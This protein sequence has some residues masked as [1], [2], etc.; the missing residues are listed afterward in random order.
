MTKYRQDHLLWETFHNGEDVLGPKNSFTQNR[1]TRWTKSSCFVYEARFGDLYFAFCTQS[2]YFS[3][4]VVLEDI[5]P[6]F[7]MSLDGLLFSLLID[8]IL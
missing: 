7:E 3:N 5:I 8:G 1:Q 2:E 6:R 4:A